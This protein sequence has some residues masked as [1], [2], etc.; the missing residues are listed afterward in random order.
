MGGSGTPAAEREDLPPPVPP[1]AEVDLYK[2][3]N[4]YTGLPERP[5]RRTEELPPLEAAPT[6]GCGCG[7]LLPRNGRRHNG[8]PMRF[9]QGHS[10]RLRTREQRVVAGRKASA[11]MDGAERVS[12][13]P[14][15]VAELKAAIA[16]GRYVPFA[17]LR[18][19]IAGTYRP[20]E[21]WRRRLG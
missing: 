12:A 1:P 17:E 2:E 7:G 14:T 11:T 4:S 6:C 8:Q 20:A 15:R 13:D 3:S 9:L 19:A 21:A 5:V 10:T 18:R 16:E